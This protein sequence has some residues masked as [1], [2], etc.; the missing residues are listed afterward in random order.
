MIKSEGV[1]SFYK[2]LQMALIA[3]TAS[4]GSY[5]FLYRLL[6]NLMFKLL[7][8]KELT[9]RHIAFITAIAGS[10]SAAFSNPF[11]FINTR[12]TLKNKENLG[13]HRSSMMEV[14]KQIYKEEGVQAFY[15]GVV[16]NMILV[17][18]PIINFVFYEAIKK[19]FT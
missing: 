10:G 16:A 17:L 8:I 3:T 18:N 6:K 14:V 13:T 1:A 11:W 5:F 15:K 2:G 4:Y 9:K 19:N 12:M 7:R